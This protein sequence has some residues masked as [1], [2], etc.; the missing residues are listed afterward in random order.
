MKMRTLD[1]VN[2]SLSFAQNI[3]QYLIENQDTADAA[4]TYHPHLHYL[5]EQHDLYRL[6]TPRTYRGHE[7]SLADYYRIMIDIARGHPAIGWNLTLGAS[8][9]LIVGSHWPERAQNELMGSGIDFIA[10]HKAFPAGVCKK[11]AGGFVV[12]GIFKYCTGITYATHAIL[13]T[14][15]HESGLTSSSINVIIPRDN[16][17]ILP[18]WGGSQTLGMR[19]SGSNSIEVKEIFVPD[20][21]AVPFKNFFADQ[22]ITNG[23][24]GTRLH[25][26]P[27]YLGYMMVPYH[28][29]LLAPIIG[30]AKASLDVFMDFIQAST[31]PASTIDTYHRAY[32]RATILTDVAESILFKVCVDHDDQSFRWQS[33]GKAVSISENIRGWACLQQAGLQA[34]EAIELLFRIS[35][36]SAAHEKS[37]LARYFC[38]AQMYRSHAGS[39]WE[40]FAP[41]VAR[42]QLGLPLD[43]MDL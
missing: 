40:N 41:Y 4:G 26:N 2:A 10:A 35:G 29:N 31:R 28:A 38:D 3:R 21:M 8:H 6:L 22:D 15:S 24:P 25:G 37:K 19:A 1:I 36:S 30:A 17:S 33:T 11:V 18:D 27:M 43:F 14:I 23:T 32:G 42:A 7:V 13:N 12:T 39:Q 5:F 34:C 20:Y 9:S 16:Y